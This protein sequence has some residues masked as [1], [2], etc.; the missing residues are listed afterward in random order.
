LPAIPSLIISSVLL[1]LMYLMSGNIALIFFPGFML[2]YLIYASMHYAIHAW[3]PPFNWL[4][5]LWRNHHLHHYANEEKGFGV[6]SMFWDRVFGTTFDLKKYKVDR[7][8]SR[9]LMFT[10]HATDTLPGKQPG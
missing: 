4:K 8:K 2:G 3:K 1:G 5:P 7:E 9:E 10:D 6:S